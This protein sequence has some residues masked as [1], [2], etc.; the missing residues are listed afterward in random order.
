[1]MKPELL[2]EDTW[3]I[4]DAGVRIFILKGKEKVLV[5][6]TGRSGID[7][8][9]LL[10]E[11]LPYELLNTHADMDHIAGNHFFPFFYMHPSEAVVYYNLNKGTGKFLPVYD[12]EIIDLGDR[13]LEIVHVPGHTPGSISVLDRNQR[14]L[15]GGDPIQLHGQIYMF[16]IHRDLH[17]YVYGLQRLMQRTDFD[18]IYPSHAEI[19]VDRN[20]ILG[21]IDG[22]ESILAGT[23]AGKT[24]MMHGKEIIAYDIGDNTLLCDFPQKEE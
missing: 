11:G 12:G 19:S 2:F 21:L 17:S 6:D 4:E 10:P 1:M 7:V 3:A 15:I 5:I 18:R 8:R 22:T 20:A 24:V 14:T 13:P 16:G 23:A 9:P